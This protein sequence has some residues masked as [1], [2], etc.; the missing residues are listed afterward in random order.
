MKNIINYYYGLFPDKVIH[1]ENIFYF[2]FNKN[3]YYFVPFINDENMVLTIY[4]KFLSEKKKINKILL[5]K[6]GKLVTKYKNSDYAMIMVDCI[7]NE[8]IEL[9]NFYNI[10]FEGKVSDWAKIWEQKLDY[11]EY[12]VN[13]RGLGKDNILNSFSYYV[14]LGEN[15]IQY[16]NF[17]DKKEVDTGIQHKRL[18]AKN[19]EINYYNPL[20]M[21]IDYS[22]RDLAEYIKFL[23]FFGDF[24]EEKIIRYLDKLSLNNS[25]FNLF[26]AR[27]LFP[28]Y[29]FDFYEKFINDEEDDNNLLIILAKSTDF[30]IFL[31]NMYIYFSNKYQLIRIEWFFW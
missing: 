17:V 19:Y 29:Y 15:A 9:E 30:E 25:M 31:K 12:Q 26:Y 1:Q 16:Y 5:N 6:F 18:Y 14:G 22:V 20:N 2:W 23:F 27:L 8:I 28:T 11:F 3:K 24:K 21:I 4:E 7:E 10:S 13:Q